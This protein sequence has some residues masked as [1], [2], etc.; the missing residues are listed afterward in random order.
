M[1]RKGKF[2]LIYEN[3]MPKNL[4]IIHANCQG[5][6]LKSL[7][8]G[9]DSFAKLFTIEKYTNYLKENISAKSL[10]QCKLFIYQHMGNH[11]QEHATEALLQKLPTSCLC[12]RIPNMF[13]NGYWPLWTNKTHMAYGDILL[14][15]LCKSSLNFHD[16]L[17]IFLR[18]NLAAKYDL[19]KYV[20]LSRAK[21]E[22]KE[23]MPNDQGMNVSSLNIIDAY[24]QEEQL[25]YT[26]NH[27]AAR[28]SLHVADSVL[29]LLNLGEVP[30]S[31]RRA[32]QALEEEF[33][34]PIH[35]QVGKYFA[36]PFAHETRLY[37]VYGQKMTFA[38]YAAAYA[39]CRLQKEAQAITDFVVYL[40][41]LAKK[42]SLHEQHA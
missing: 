5:D 1:T 11:W 28:L 20:A 33:E 38:Q 10:A 7:L 27:P 16:I 37:N 42:A 34:Q 15:H 26:V 4:C 9:S 6:N 19:Q 14:E 13:F 12:I 40:H 35:P 23:H 36:L 3:F 39:N 8:S 22:V 32:Y 17:H 21:E 25:F 2:Y 31:L 30:C 18:G 41:L 29:R 24:W